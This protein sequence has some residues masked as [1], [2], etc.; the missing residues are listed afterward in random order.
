MYFYRTSHDEREAEATRPPYVL[1]LEEKEA[2]HGQRP[3]LR[4]KDL[5][6]WEQVG[7]AR[8]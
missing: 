2:R 7:G 1:R 8:G 4:S 5:G 6:E 3:G